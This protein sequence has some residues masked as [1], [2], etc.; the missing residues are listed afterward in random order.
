MKKKILAVV[1]AAVLA[2]GC[3]SG[4]LAADKDYK[5][6][7][8]D[9]AYALEKFLLAG[10]TTMVDDDAVKVNDVTMTDVYGNR[11]AQEV[12]QTNI[13]EAKALMF[14]MLKKAAGTSTNSNVL[15]I[16]NVAYDNLDEDNG[17]ELVF[18]VDSVKKGDKI[19]MFHWN[20]KS[21]DW[22]SGSNWVITKITDKH[23]YA[24]VKKLSPVAFVKNANNATTGTGSSSGEA[25]TTK[26]ATGAK[27]APKTGE[28]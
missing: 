2:L 12:G 10:V 16:F 7:T 17:T 5:S 14:N 13:L 21:L 18:F 4:A 27:A 25:T 8:M 1:T 22:E 28:V 19:G 24:K 3:A 9:K 26:A 6:A 11:A 23:I 20:N 15:A